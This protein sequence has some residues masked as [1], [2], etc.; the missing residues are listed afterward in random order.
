MSVNRLVLLGAGLVLGTSCMMTT[1]SAGPTYWGE[2]REQARLQAIS[3]RPSDHGTDE[4]V[5]EWARHP[6]WTVA[7]S[8]VFAAIPDFAAPI[9]KRFADLSVD[10]QRALLAYAGGVPGDASSALVLRLS[11]AGGM[12][13]EGIAALAGKQ[14]AAAVQGLLDLAQSGTGAT[15]IAAI[16]ALE[17]PD[18]ALA[19]D[20][21][22]AL[23]APGNPSDVRHAAVE[24]LAPYALPEVRSAMFALV[25]GEDTD[26]SASVLDL[27]DA[28]RSDADVTAGLAAT[29][30]PANGPAAVRFLNRQATP[31]ASVFERFRALADAA[32][33]VDAAHRGARF[34]AATALVDRGDLAGAPALVQLLDDDTF[35]AR[36]EA[37]L[38]GLT[39]ASLPPLRAHGPALT[40]AAGMAEAARLLA[41]FGGPVDEPAITAL[42]T[43]VDKAALVASLARAPYGLFPEGKV[44]YT[45]ALQGFDGPVERT[46]EDVITEGRTARATVSDPVLAYFG[47]AR[48]YLAGARSR[49][50]AQA[51]AAAATAARGSF[52]FVVDN[53]LDAGGSYLSADIGARVADVA[54]TRS[55][56]PSLPQRGSKLIPAADLSGKLACTSKDHVEHDPLASMTYYYTVIVTN[57]NKATLKSYMDNYPYDKRTVTDCTKTCYC[58]VAGQGSTTYTWSCDSTATGTGSCNCNT[59]STT[60]TSP[61]YAQAIADYNAEPEFLEQQ[62][63]VPKY[64]TRITQVHNEGCDGPIALAVGALTHK[65]ELHYAGEKRDWIVR[66]E[67][68][69]THPEGGELPMFVSEDEPG[70]TDNRA[71][72]LEAAVNSAL[73]GFAPTEAQIRAM[74]AAAVKPAVA[75]A[76]SRAARDTLVWSDPSLIGADAPS[77]DHFREVL[78]SDGATSFPTAWR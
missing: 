16:R 31:P 10:Q 66:S 64:R 3:E 37:T 30:G 60:S 78:L 50:D 11:T 25:A 51:L 68:K 43:P 1:T 6:D 56:A 74:Y 18:T 29:A 77:L 67:A 48:A 22:I 72:N 39:L 26:V 54:H 47:A 9:E 69:P 46:L 65:G 57:P 5:Q 19:R 62:L 34:E 8:A 14:D 73:Y 28:P 71:S 7:Q 23:G 36:C 45:P 75:K 49:P 24:V 53:R 20:G 76:D 55:G 52:G 63:S 12:I 35:R 33:V 61:G 4:A 13:D 2:T 41:R 27:F 40:T 42:A 15:R 38:D 32:A 70:H 21:L 44:R 59:T 58:Y 17:P